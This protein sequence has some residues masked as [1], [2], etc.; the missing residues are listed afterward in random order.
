MLS[1]DEEYVKISDTEL[2]ESDGSGDKVLESI[3]SG[4]EEEVDE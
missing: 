1:E 3:V 2:E 4:A